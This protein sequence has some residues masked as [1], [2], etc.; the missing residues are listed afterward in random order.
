MGPLVPGVEGVEP[1]GEV[2]DGFGFEGESFEE[3][4]VALLIVEVSDLA[5]DL[6]DGPSRAG[7]SGEGGGALGVGPGVP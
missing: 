3:L 1:V 7:G 2:V 6:V 5:G 4:V